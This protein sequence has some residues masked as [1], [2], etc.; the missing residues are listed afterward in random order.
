MLLIKENNDSDIVIS[1]AVDNGTKSWFIEGKMIQCNKPN[2]NN[3]MYVTEHMDAEVARYTQNYIKENRALGELNHP[4]TADID[5]SRVSH[6][7]VRLER[8]GNDFYGKA[9]I[10]SSTPMGNIAE[11][12]IKE[13]VKMGVST[14]GLGSLVKMNGFNQVQPDF[15]LVAVDLVSDPSAQDAYVMALREGK[16][17]VW[18]NE[19]LPESQVNQQ[20]K[21]LKKA[22]SRKLEEAAI[23][24]FKDFMRSL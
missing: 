10:L 21:T 12:L 4:P 9:K 1:E 13:G 14:R 6:K 15:K 16:E 18:A 11:N 17:W 20:Y 2:K 22:S 5:L 19:F 3:R 8:N 23:K 24:I 7:I